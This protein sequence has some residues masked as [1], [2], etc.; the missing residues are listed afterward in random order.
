MVRVRDAIAVQRRFIAD[1]S[2]QLRTRWR[3]CERRPSRRCAKRSPPPSAR[4]SLN[5]ATIPSH[6]SPGQPASLAGA[7]RTAWPGWQTRRRSSSWRPSREVCAALVPDALAQRADLGF[8]EEG[9]A[10]IRA[11]PLLIRELI[12]NLVDNALRY[13]PQ[14]G[15]RARR[16][17]SPERVLLVVE[18]D[19]PVFR[20][21]ERSRVFERFYRIR[22]R[23]GDGAGLG[24]PSCT[25]S[26]ADT[27]ASS[28]SPMVRGGK[29]LQSR[30]AFRPLAPRRRQRKL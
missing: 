5:C 20:A 29:G 30:S 24:S 14:D 3:C 9:P 18:D 19:G 21:D 2:H 22:E 27:G 8:E 17:L 1:A 15:H 26:P 12:A 28:T 11:R 6:Q 25:R 10:L 16:A 4:C 13:A 23:A 7:R